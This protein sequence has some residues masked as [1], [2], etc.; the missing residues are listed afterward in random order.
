MTSL[1]AV[2]TACAPAEGVAVL[3]SGSRGNAVLAYSGTRGVLVDCGISARQVRLRIE[4]AGLAGVRIEAVALT[5]EHAD[6]TAG[7][8][9]LART[10]EVPVL[11]TPGTLHAASSTLAD[12]PETAPLRLGDAIRVAGLSLTPF[13]SS[14]DAAEPVGFRISFPSGRALGYLS[15][16]G[17]LTDETLEALAACEVLA[18]EA[19]H[20]LE[21]LERGPYPAFLKARIRSAVG[22]LSNDDA[23][24]GLAALAH[25][26]LNT[27]IGLHLSEQNNTPHHAL[28]ALGRARERL[29]IDARVVAASQHEPLVCA[30]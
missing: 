11:A 17:V 25:D 7:V 4:A 18:V 13:R 27:V 6:H 15:D 20:D 28:S 29:G 14:H 16:S 22:H 24:A 8:R 30:V 19:N 3:A 23:A 21:M 10:L 1:H 5:H 26:G 2:Q 9:V 12:V